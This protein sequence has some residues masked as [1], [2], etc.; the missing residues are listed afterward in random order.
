MRETHGIQCGI[1]TLM[2]IRTYEQI[3]QLTPN[4]KKA[5]A[6]VEAFNA[7]SWNDTLRQFLGSGADAMIQNERKEGKYD[8]AKH[9]ARLD[10]IIEKWEEILQIIHEEIP[11]YDFVESALLAVGAPTTP[12]QIG[13]SREETLG[14]FLTA[15]DIRDKYVGTRLLWDLGCLEDVADQLYPV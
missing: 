6:Y 8:K 2:G 1:G 4:K 15:K 12:A 5:L 14:A 9:A 11:S 7:E 13:I 3:R 10:L